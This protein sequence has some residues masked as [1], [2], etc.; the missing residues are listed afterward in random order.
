MLSGPSPLGR[1]RRASVPA[2][3]ASPTPVCVTRHSPVDGRPEAYQDPLVCTTRHSPP[4]PGA[5]AREP[6]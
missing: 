5:V 4:L 3:G 1:F 6:Q 2:D